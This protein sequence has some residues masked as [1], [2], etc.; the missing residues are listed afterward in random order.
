MTTMRLATTLTASD[1]DNRTLS[2]KVLPFGEVGRTNLGKVQV[3]GPGIVSLPAKPADSTLNIEHERTRPVGRGVMIAERADG[4]YADFK[5][6]ATSAGDDLLIEAAEGLRASASVELED[7]VI[8][9]G[10][11]LAGRLTDVAA[12]VNP[13]YPSATLIAA[14]CGDNPP[15]TAGGS[16]STTA[17]AGAQLQ[18]NA[19]EDLVQAVT[20]VAADAAVAIVDGED[21]QAAVA[22]PAAS[23]ALTAA[24]APIGVQAPKLQAVKTL[25]HTILTASQMLANI[26]KESGA[27]KR[28]GGQLLAALAEIASAGILDVTTPE[29]FEGKIW[30]GTE[31]ER[32]HVD[33]IDNEAL[34]KLEYRGWKWA[35]DVAGVSKKPVMAA[36]AGFPAEPPTGP[37]EAART[38]WEPELIAWAGRLDR[39]FR[40]FSDPDFWSAFFTAISTSYAEVTDKTHVLA[41]LWDGGTSVELALLDKPADVPE[42]VWKLV[43]GIR[44][45]LKYGMPTGARLHT[46]L[47][48]EIMFTPQDQVLP[49]LQLAMG[50]KDG[51]ALNFSIKPDE[52]VLTEG[53][54]LVVVKKA[55]VFRELPGSPIRVDAEV[56][57]KGG[58]EQGVFGYAGTEIREARAIAAVSTAA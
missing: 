45:V 55:A 29:S 19:A 42:G 16:M 33:L 18:A 5:I 24:R 38:D 57:S 11:L 49:Y 6:A 3:D 12:V 52:E 53:Q 44:A 56:I 22:D 43:K 20:A 48:E 35:K 30:E 32:Q 40:D 7:V 8:R 17:Q 2:Y 34:T 25:P 9:G 50:V 47:W 37:V 46:D 4:I 23:P 54:V 26:A 41:T 1:L 10:K 13:A 31:Y 14:D 27:G 36:Y 39:K 28:M 15:I 21:P 58:I 51:Q